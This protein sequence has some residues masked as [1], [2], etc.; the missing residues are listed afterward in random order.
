MFF[1]WR[2]AKRVQE[3]SE[4]KSVDRFT[5]NMKG[6]EAYRKAWG[7]SFIQLGQGCK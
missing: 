1:L 6:S 2:R 5:D 7:T 4:C 3:F